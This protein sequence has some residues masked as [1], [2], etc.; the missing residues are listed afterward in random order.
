MVKLV[1]L[2]SEISGINVSN[3]KWNKFS[4]MGC[5]E[6][7]VAIKSEIHSNTIHG[8]M[9]HANARSALCIVSILKMCLSALY[10]LGWI[11]SCSRRI[12]LI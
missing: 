9:L 5:V 7:L 10:S 1:S 11:D 6:R 8:P 12:F 3:L 4:T 2:K